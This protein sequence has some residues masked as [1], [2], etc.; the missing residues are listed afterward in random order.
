[1]IF[2]EY[3]YQNFFKSMSGLWI[4]DFITF[5]SSSS[6]VLKYCG[7]KQVAVFFSFITKFHQ[8]YLAFWGKNRLPFCRLMSNEWK[9]EIDEVNYFLFPAH[10]LVTFLHLRWY[11]T[12]FYFWLYFSSCSNYSTSIFRHCKSR[13]IATGAEKY[14]RVTTTCEHMYSYNF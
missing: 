12:Q 13:S 4:E 10:E 5:S 9:R 6:P 1:M 3:S 7:K 8:Y 11:W 2:G 14:I